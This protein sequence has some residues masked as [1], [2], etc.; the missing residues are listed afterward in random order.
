MSGDKLAS[1]LLQLLGTPSAPA[2]RP[3]SWCS[4]SGLLMHI[5]ACLGSR[6]G[7]TGWPGSWGW[8]ADWRQDSAGCEPPASLPPPP[9]LDMP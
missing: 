9:A 1:R 5:L 2:L 8:G 4:C 3:A 7:G 6:V